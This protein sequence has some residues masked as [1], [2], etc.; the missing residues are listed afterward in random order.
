MEA[1]DRA[2]SP[3]DRMAEADPVQRKRKHRRR[4]LHQRLARLRNQLVA[5]VKAHEVENRVLRNLDL[6]L[7][8]GALA[9][10]LTDAIEGEE[11]NTD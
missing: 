11:I 7:A 1:L 9:E 4:A 3:A 8:G 2:L 5:V 10:A 6:F